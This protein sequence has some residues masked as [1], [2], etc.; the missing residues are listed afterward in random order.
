MASHSD[1]VNPLRPYY[2]PPSI[3]PLPGPLPGSAATPSPHP[4]AFSHGGVAGAK[5]ASRARDMLNDL[6]YKDYLSD[7]SPSVVQ[8]I[9]ELLDELL[10][11]YTVVLIAQPFSV[12]KTILQVRCQDD[13]A[14]MSP[15]AVA[16]QTP[17]REAQNNE[18]QYV[19][20]IYNYPD[21]SDS[22]GDEAAYF[23]S[24]VPA[25]PTPSLPRSR[26]H[27]RQISS[28]LQSP[29]PPRDLA[30]PKTAHHLD[31]RQP[32][33]TRAVISQLWQKESAWGVWK[34]ANATFIY[35]VLQSLLE[36]WSRSC[37]SALFN[38][39]D[40]GVK[41][42]IDRLVDIASPYPWA[43][44]CVA[45]AA[46]VSTGLILAPLDIVRTRFVV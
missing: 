7:P 5:Y 39:P 43:S 23:T 8:T 27:S 14:A 42:D 6:D 11:K 20:S 31:L 2:V 22:D 40:L 9:R 41:D 46:A 1:G 38:V 12:A 35:T 13:G 26:Q 3:G 34:G 10:W 30:R 25:T 33:S 28:P 4:N 24:N 32:D 21:D 15:S 18:S 36:N 16:P 37:L 17:R 45:A 44:L 19:G 29:R